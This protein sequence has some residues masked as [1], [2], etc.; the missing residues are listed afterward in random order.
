MGTRFADEFPCRKTTYNPSYGQYSIGNCLKCTVG[1]FCKHGISEP[2]Q[3]LSGTY[4]PGYDP[5][6][7][8]VT[9]L[10]IGNVSD[11]LTCPEG[12]FC[13]RGSVD[14]VDC[15]VGKYSRPGSGFCVTC[16]VGH[17]CNENATSEYN[18]RKNKQCVPGNYCIAGL[19]S[20][21]ESELCDAGFYCPQAA[22]EPVA[23]PPGTYNPFHGKSSLSDCLSCD[24]GYY[25][26][27]N[28]TQPSGPCH[29]GFYCPTNISNGE[30]NSSYG[31]TQMPC[32]G[33][34]LSGRVCQIITE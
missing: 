19:T 7:G 30:M 4:N 12:Q 33:G 5:S 15:G 20:F 27:E 17:V 29:P 1:H 25:C 6:L 26:L 21:D 24:A 9:G 34:N 28:V 3:C 8:V 22:I 13:V 2:E 23:C 32:P 11:C 14:P 10:P 16:L 18:M 31:P